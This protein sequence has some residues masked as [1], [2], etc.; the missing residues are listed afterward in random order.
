[1]SFRVIAEALLR[2][3]VY[4]GIR[5]GACLREVL[6]AEVIRFIVLGAKQVAIERDGF[7]PT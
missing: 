5:S 3:K 1:M 6:G 7:K 4:E 2:A